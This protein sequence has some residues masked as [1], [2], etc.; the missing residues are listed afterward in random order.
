[1]TR[2]YTLRDLKQLK[3][4]LGREFGECNSAMALLVTQT[5]NQL[6]RVEAQQQRIIDLLER[7]AP[8]QLAAG[9][10][11]IPALGDA[12]QLRLVDAAADTPA[13]ELLERA[14]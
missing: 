2:H 9:D 6:A 4:E 7:V 10:A 12:P 14:A 13:G 5:R 1:M 8:G 11:H 3:E